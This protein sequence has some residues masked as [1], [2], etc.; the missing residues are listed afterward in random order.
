MANNVDHKTELIHV[1]HMAYSGEKAAAY[2]YSGHW[3][4]LKDPE[5]R[6]GI[7]TI[8]EEELEH[9]KLV[10]EMLAF[11]SARPQ[12]WREFMMACIGRTVGVACFLI[13]W[14][15]PMYFAGRLEHAN[16]NEYSVA[17][18][19]A[20]KL[21]L[22]EFATELRR[23]STVELRHEQFFFDVIQGHALLPVISTLFHWGKPNDVPAL[24]A[25]P[26]DEMKQNV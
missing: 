11:L 24:R 6:K 15:L 13:G 9:R 7:Q 12:P 16:V 25:Y 4:S 19:H 1:L 14:F 8:E 2:A 18:Y 26:P 23:L 3:K 17:A 20:D 22:N 10:G 5:Q 21:G